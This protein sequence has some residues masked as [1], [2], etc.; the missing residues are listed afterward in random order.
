MTR[1]IVRKFRNKSI[2]L[3]F[4]VYTIILL[5]SASQGQMGPR[6]DNPQRSSSA[7]SMSGEPASSHS[8]GTSLRFLP[9]VT[10]DAGAGA[11]GYTGS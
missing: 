3:L 5:A 2:E 6:I 8:E 4:A 7:R 11:D 10:Y 1:Q 9:A